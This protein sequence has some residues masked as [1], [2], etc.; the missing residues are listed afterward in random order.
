MHVSVNRRLQLRDS[1]GI[2]G[3]SAPA[4]SA[5]ERAIS[6]TFAF[7]RAASFT[8]GRNVGSTTEAVRCLKV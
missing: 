7:E 6:F 1:S 2:T 4:M 3:V 5:A 8:Q